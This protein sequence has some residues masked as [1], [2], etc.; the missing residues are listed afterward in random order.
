MGGAVNLQASKSKNKRPFKVRLVDDL[1]DQFKRAWANRL[2]ECRYV[3]HDRGQPIG[4]FR[5]A[6]RNVKRAVGLAS[7][8][9]HD[10]RRSAAHNLDHAG[11]TQARAMKITGHLTDSMWRRYNIV[12][13]AD[14]EDDMERVSAYNRERSGETPKIVPLRQQA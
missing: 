7:L 12:G 14:L 3:F 5:K 6:W 4:D 1:L 8:L 9:I 11:V 10:M 2:P 13:D